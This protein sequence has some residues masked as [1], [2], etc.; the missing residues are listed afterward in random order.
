MAGTRAPQ[1]GQ[2][3]TQDVQGTKEARV[4]KVVVCQNLA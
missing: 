2:R 4:E 3:G 1:D